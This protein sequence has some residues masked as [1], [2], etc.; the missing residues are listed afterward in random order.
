MRGGLLVSQGW[1]L[2][3]N[4]WRL[5]RSVDS[6]GERGEWSKRGRGFGGGV[7]LT[8]IEYVWESNLAS[9]WIRDLMA[10]E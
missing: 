1:D 9:S 8:R 2:L 5:R 10:E 3:W 7:C 4:D 6:R